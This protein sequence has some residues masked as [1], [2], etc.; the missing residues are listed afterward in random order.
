MPINLTAPVLT[1][2][3][4]VQQ[5]VIGVLSGQI[6]ISLSNVE[7]LPV[8]ANAVGVSHTAFVSHVSVMVVHIN[9]V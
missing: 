6:N 9:C 2:P 5:A 8:L 7:P 4:I 3:E 1:R